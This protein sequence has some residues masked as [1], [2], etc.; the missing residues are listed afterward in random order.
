MG[1]STL[2]SLLVLP[3]VFVCLHVSFTQELNQTEPTRGTVDSGGVYNNA[4]LGMTIRLPGNWQLQNQGVAHGARD[5]GCTGPLCGDPEIDI[6]M[7]PGRSAT[8]GYRVFLAAWKLSAEY[9]DRHQYPLKW[10]ARSMTTGSLG[11]SN[12][13]PVGELSPIQLSGRSAYRL[14]VAKPGEKEVK[15]CGYV[16]EANGYVFLLVASA[17]SSA[18]EA[19][20]QT[21][22]ER[23][24]FTK[25]SR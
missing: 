4:V 15:A 19:A 11:G 14:L 3:A 12:W 7:I 1:L 23:L 18:E 6:A 10:F 22:I 25:S 21:A 16:S 5:P 17:D 8:P 13:I 2:R 20:L 9:R 24:E